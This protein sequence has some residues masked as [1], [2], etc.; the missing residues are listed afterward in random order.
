[1]KPRSNPPP[2]RSSAFLELLEERIAPAIVEG[3]IA[4]AVAGTPILLGDG[5]DSQG[6]QL[7]RGLGSD[8]PYAG[9]Y[10]LYVEK[11]QALVFTT[12]LNGDN[13]VDPNEITGIAAGNGL[14]LLSFV[15]INGD[16]V[17]NLN[18]DGTLTDSDG[19]AGNGR[20]GRVVLDSRIDGITLRSVTDQDLDT[21]E[22]GNTAFNRLVESRYSIYGNIYAGGGLG[23]LTAEGASG[24]T[25]T[26]GVLM[27]TSGFA[28]QN[29]KYSNL[30]FNDV[31]PTPSLG[32]I[33]TGSAVSGQQFS[34]GTSVIPDAANRNAGTLI[35]RGALDFFTPAAGEAGGSVV[36]IRAVTGTDQTNVDYYIGGI[37]TGNGGF[38]A[39]GGDIREVT[40][41]GD[42]GGFFAIAGNGGNGVTGGAG[43]SVL[44]LVATAS[45][46]STVDIR[47]GNGGFGLLGAA[48]K[49]GEFVAGGELELYGNVSI[50]LGRGGDSTGNAGNGTGLSSATIKQFGPGATAPVNFISTMRA[51]GDLG[52]AT[53]F[54]FNGDTFEDAVFLTQNTQQLGVAFGDGAGGF[55]FLILE[56]S[57][58]AASDL[59]M[60][61]VAVVD[62]N[63]DGFAE[64]ITASSSGTTFGG[65]KTFWNLGL[66]ENSGKWL[67]FDTPRYSPSP[68]G[69]RGVDTNMAVGDFD[70]DGIIDVAL[71]ENFRFLTSPISYGASIT[72]L[73]GLKGAGGQVDG[74]FA[75]NYAKN[76]STGASTLEPSTLVAI[77]RS[78]EV[79]LVLKATAATSGDVNSD[80]LVALVRKIGDVNAT[81]NTYGFVSGLGGGMNSLGIDQEILFS[82]RSIIEVETSP[83]ILEPR[84]DYGRPS[85][86]DAFDFAI[87]DVEEGSPP[88]RDG[89]FDVVVFGDS[90]EFTVAAVFKGTA[91]GAL[92]AQP[93]LQDQRTT[94]PLP[95]PAN[96]PYYGIAITAPDAESGKPQIP[97][98][99][100]SELIHEVARAIE[101][102]PATGLVAYGARLE[103]NPPSAAIFTWN[104]VGYGQYA[105]I[106]TGFAQPGDGMTYVGEVAVGERDQAVL[107]ADLAMRDM[108]FGYYDTA[109]APATDYAGLSRPNVAPVWALGPVASL[110][111]GGALVTNSLELIG[112]NGGQSFLG[113]GGH[114]GSIGVGAVTPTNPRTGSITET[115]FSN[116]V[117]QAGVGGSGL[118]GG[119]DGGTLSGVSTQGL[120]R[121]LTTGAGGGSLL[122]DGGNGGSYSGN[123]FD[124]VA[125]RT[126]PSSLVVNTGE[127]G[128]GLRGGRGGDISGLGDLNFPDAIVHQLTVVGGGGGEGMARGGAGGA[129]SK[130]QPQMGRGDVG[131]LWSALL[132]DFQGGAG[133]DAVA[134]AGGVGGA[135][136]SSRTSPGYNSLYAGPLNLHAGAG[137]DGLTGGAGGTVLDFI[138]SPT[139]TVAPGVASIFGGAGGAG[140]TGAGGKGGDIG[141]VQVTALGR[142]VLTDTLLLSA[143]V[144]GSGGLSSANVAGAGGSLLAG[145]VIASTSGSLVA[146]AGTGGVGFTRGGLGGSVSGSYNASANNA[147]GGVVAIAG[148][149]GDAY[150]VNL[151]TVQKEN[152]SKVGVQ[153]S[154][155]PLFQKLWAMGTANGTAGDGGSITGYAQPAGKDVRTDLIAGNGGSTINYGLTSDKTTGAGKGGSLTKISVQG[156][157]GAWDQNLAIRS[158]VAFGQPVEN[159]VEN[160][161][162]GAVT[163]LDPSVG[164]VGAVVGQSGF[165]RNGQ[166]AGA[167]VNGSVSGFD[168]GRIMSMVAGSVDRLAVITSVSG[169]RFSQMGAF[170]A[171]A[172]DPSGGPVPV[173]VPHINGN[174]YYAG[175][176]YSGVVVQDAS[177]GGTLVDGAVL[178]RKF[179]EVAGQPNPLRL[180]TIARV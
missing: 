130:F 106:Q 70:R 95:F 139:S 18:P 149:G 121:V 66:G 32:Y 140:V 123:F 162:S 12:D 159:F 29:S 5:V 176:D 50:G 118:R 11:G 60:S 173:P 158:Y 49:A 166:P 101:I 69:D 113:R 120:A 56:P 127:G 25:A 125:T 59:R 129:I 157:V 84:L 111:L 71:V 54:D 169:V 55:E 136:T 53:P 89:N 104:V 57:I 35:V 30:W 128:F 100:P 151:A 7:P 138:N 3:G 116:A 144:G 82:P 38:G 98:V 68:F 24:T 110:P 109:G 179:I 78:A 83:G 175:S 115:G 77:R 13:N 75:A 146:A 150:A 124:G 28:T 147:N 22:I 148:A 52:T 117:F 61:P 39:K 10:Y 79:Q 143:V 15:N 160:V 27:D 80:V 62:L 134:G 34:F 91:T 44:G 41:H 103:T 43:G 86:V 168:A 164:N 133:G 105:S 108:Y 26:Y 167:G 76:P 17:T 58:Y 126:Q 122:G 137:G 131:F 180:F 156:D 4:A 165:V 94:S 63:G 81:I 177:S 142:D 85:R 42:V 114:G 73:S 112:G 72:L 40:L 155:M 88:S 102:D 51:P 141:R 2:L 107:N 172:V 36:G 48:G 45:P 19:D 8:V 9:G 154:A 92:A 99:L 90:G 47:T 93:L 119:G 37:T 67:G 87:V 74:F 145:N 174:A 14:R 33:F 97:R 1:M 16:I 96:A 163:Q 161:R 21:T 178:T 20:D 171:L 23:T 46:N 132:L 6:R 65:I 153:A 64:I 152:P 170:K 135:I 31:Q